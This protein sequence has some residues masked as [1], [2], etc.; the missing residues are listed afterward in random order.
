MSTIC[1]LDPNV[2]AARRRRVD[3]I[4]SLKGTKT[5]LQSQARS[6]ELDAVRRNPKLTGPQKDRR[7]RGI[8]RHYADR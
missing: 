2:R 7:F 3:A 5:I 6:V 4:R 1:K 8:I